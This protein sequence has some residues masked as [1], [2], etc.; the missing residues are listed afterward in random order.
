MGVR[1]QREGEGV[2]MQREGKKRRRVGGGKSIPEGRGKEERVG[3]GWT[4]K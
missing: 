4:E 1:R 3:Q 2:R